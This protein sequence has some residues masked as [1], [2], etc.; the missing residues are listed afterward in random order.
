MFIFYSSIM[1]QIIILLDFKL[2][3]FVGREVIIYKETGRSLLSF[4]FC[5]W[6][7]SSNA[8]IEVCL[9]L[10]LILKRCRYMVPNMF[11]D[12]YPTNINSLIYM[13]TKL[14][15]LF[16]YDSKTRN[17]VFRNRISPDPIFFTAEASSVGGFY[18]INRRSQVLLVTVN[19][20]T[21][22]NFVGGQVCFWT[23][24]HFHN[25]IKKLK[26]ALN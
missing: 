4:G 17:A 25:V 12:R 1:V 19:E 15:L 3:K 14:C 24:H 7:S 10:S 11:L 6:P 2:Y 9:C 5:W 21:I 23:Y 16:V 8:G 13:I 26:N 20:W 22:V 18:A